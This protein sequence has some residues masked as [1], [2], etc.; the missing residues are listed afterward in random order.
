MDNGGGS[1]Q[2]LLPRLCCP[3]KGPNGYGFHLHGE[4][5]KAGQFIR[6]VEPDSP[7]EKS[8]LR[9][10]DRLVEVNGE[11]VEKESHQQ[12]VNRIRS[13]ANSVRLLVVDPETD[14]R[15]QKLGI[16][17]CEEL[18][19]GLPEEISEGK[20]DARKVQ[21]D[22]PRD[23][24]EEEE[25]SKADT[26]LKNH[27]DQRMELR[28]R[29]CQMKK[30]PNGYGFNLHSDKTKPGQYV[31]AVDPGS[32]A[33][34]AGLLP[35]DRIIEVNGVC[36]EGKQHSDVVSAIRSGGDDTKLLVVDSLTDDF[37]K[38]CK[39]IPSEAHLKGPLPEPVANGDMEKE[40]Y[41]DDQ[42]KSATEIPSSPVPASPS[43][44]LNEAHNELNAQEKEA[45]RSSVSDPVLD[46]DIPLAVAK[47]RAHQKR[48]NKRAPQMDWSKKNELF[49]NL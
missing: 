5:G 23:L 38:K 47:E 32:P 42:P 30:G 18:I 46:L 2:Q 7:A 17:C 8:G 35:Q 28:P 40:N 37:F 33:E 15:L 36:M 29:L 44:S 39:V 20:S 49:S 22:T 45:H 12:V 16:A 13:A 25:R 31:R 6:L 43:P 9:A 10:G 26:E 14:E 41:T 3:E 27:A 21:E 48:T 24:K 1:E 34:S 4:K 19:R 11:N